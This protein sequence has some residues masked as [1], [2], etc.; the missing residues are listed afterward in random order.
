MSKLNV[1][2]S[3]EICLRFSNDI[4]W[5]DECICTMTHD[6]LLKKI[7]KTFFGTWGIHPTAFN[8]LYNIIK[9]IAKLHKS[10]YHQE[11]GLAGLF[12]CEC[13]VEYP[14]PTIQAF[15]KDLKSHRMN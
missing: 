10:E 1:A 12:C 11:D 4:K 9:A 7:D 15:E 14:C 2:E 3:A 13:E 8:S 5:S 6:E